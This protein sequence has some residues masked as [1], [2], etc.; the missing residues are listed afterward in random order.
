MFHV[1]FE[2]LPNLLTVFMGIVLEAGPFLLFGVLVSS[3]LEVAVST[4]RLSRIFPRNRMLGLMSGVALGAAAPLCECGTVPIARGSISRGLPV[5]SAV[6]F[7]LAA[8][9][10]NPITVAATY[11]AFHD[12]LS[13]LGLRV[14][15]GVLVAI[16]VG[17]LFLA[18]PGD[19]PVL[20]RSAEAVHHH[21]HS[22]SHPSFRARVE[23]VLEHSGHEL[24]SLMIYLMAAAFVASALQVLVPRTALVSL[25]QGPLLSVVIMM[26]IAVILST[27]SSV[28]AFVALAFST[29]FAPGA[30]LAFLLI[31]PVLNLKS[32]ALVIGLF[33][34]R[35]VIPLLA[36]STATILVA[37]LAVNYHLL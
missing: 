10:I 18:W 6:G 34:A 28:D 25:G 22:A 13:M 7:L 5:A 33:R 1:L 14:V 20:R 16:A 17:G 9:V 3:T 36:A 2:R 12:N 37:A 27:C 24:T 35:A 31:S 23:A 4:E 15:F 32:G 8:P 21:D 29:T 30:I 19:V 26:L 11:T